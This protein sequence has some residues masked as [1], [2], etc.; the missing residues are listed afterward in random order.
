MYK[1]SVRLRAL[2]RVRLSLNGAMLT[3]LL[4]SGISL[5]HA[6][7][8]PSFAALL[9]QAQLNALIYSNRPPMSE[10]PVPMHA[11]PPL[12]RILRSVSLPKTSAP[13]CPAGRTS[14]RIPM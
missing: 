11:R 6:A 10:Q 14:A 13:H 4:G 5:S 7:E 3:L 2:S 9:Q 8:T 12:G 1:I